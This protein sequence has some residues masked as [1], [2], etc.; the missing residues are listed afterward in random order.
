M[1]TIQRF[2]LDQQAHD[3]AGLLAQAQY[4]LLVVRERQLRAADE[5]AADLHGQVLQAEHVSDML[6]DRI[7]EVANVAGVGAHGDAR[8]KLERIEGMLQAQASALAELGAE[9]ENLRLP[10]LPPREPAPQELPFDAKETAGIF[11]RALQGAVVGRDLG[12]DELLPWCAA[13]V[14][15]GYDEHARKYGKLIELAVMGDRYNQGSEY[16]ARAESD[17]AH[18][19]DKFVDPGA[20]PDG[21]L[22]PE[23]RTF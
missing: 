3:A 20:P 22:P 13:I 9:L 8:E 16:T 23:K 10:P 5:S 14:M 17:I 15:R 12:V 1:K 6:M 21:W 2:T 4:Q 7:H 18:E 19:A 11:V